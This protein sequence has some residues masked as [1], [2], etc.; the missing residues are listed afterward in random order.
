MKTLARAG[1]DV[2]VISPFPLREPIANYHDIIVENGSDGTQLKLVGNFLLSND[3]LSDESVNMF[4]SEDWS[5]IQLINVLSNV[6]EFLAN[7]TLSHP[8]VKDLMKY[9]KNF[10]AVIVEVFWVEALY[11][12]DQISEC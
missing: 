7:S 12:K 6:G 4:E 8:N 2:H 3:Q 1:H 11:G 9:E 5:A 10:D